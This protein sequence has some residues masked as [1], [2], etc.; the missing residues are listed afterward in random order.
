MPRTFSL[1]AALA[2]T[3]SGLVFAGCSHLDTSAPATDDRVV[4]GVV[5]T[6]SEEALPAGSEVWVGVIDVSRGVARPEVLGEQTITDATHL[7]VEFRIEFRAA[8]AVLRQ[9][10]SILSRISV[11][12]KLKYY[13]A[14][15]HPLTPGNLSEPQTVA[16]VPATQP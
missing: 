10:V 3:V 1:L 14:S 13:T 15:E 6:G 5:S 7:P 16:V 8:D 11:G 12:R 4:T 2:F 9:S